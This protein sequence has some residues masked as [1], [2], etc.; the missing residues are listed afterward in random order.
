MSLMKASKID[1][2]T[3]RIRTILKT[4]K[5][6]KQCRKEIKS[7]LD[8]L[9]KDAKADQLSYMKKLQDEVTKFRQVKELLK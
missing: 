1:L 2:A 6:D 3:F 7:I 8:D 9:V 5:T 4:N